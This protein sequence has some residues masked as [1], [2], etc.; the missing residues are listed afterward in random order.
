MVTLIRHYRVES[1]LDP[2][3]QPNAKSAR[4]SEAVMNGGN[5]LLVKKKHEN[6]PHASSINL[7]RSH[8]S[9]NNILYKIIDL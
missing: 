4:P 2:V 7:K 9:W 5:V 3:V 1:K 6:R 8:D